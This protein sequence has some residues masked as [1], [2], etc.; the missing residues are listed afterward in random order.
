M[1]A[2]KSFSPKTLEKLE[3][4]ITI[5][6]GNYYTGEV[7]IELFPIIYKVFLDEYPTSKWEF[8]FYK[9]RDHM[10]ESVKRFCP[11]ILVVSCWW[12]HS[13]WSNIPEFINEFLYETIEDRNKSGSLKPFIV[14]TESWRGRFSE[15]YQQN[16]HYDIYLS[17]SDFDEQFI[18]F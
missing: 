11:H 9:G 17:I 8:I 13:G 16:V 14:L 5:G 7:I 3:L 1:V 15:L 10:I 18:I 2:D 12:G 6:I 4:P